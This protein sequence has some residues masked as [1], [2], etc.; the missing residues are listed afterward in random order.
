MPLVGRVQE[1]MY[2]YYLKG[3]QIPSGQ[4]NYAEVV[5]MILALP[6]VPCPAAGGNKRR[7]NLKIPSI[8]R[9]ETDFSILKRERMLILLST[10]SLQGFLLSSFWKRNEK[11]P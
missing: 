8:C 3:N 7:E 5:A 11:I 9:G 4:K 10:S 2:E 6:G 1:L